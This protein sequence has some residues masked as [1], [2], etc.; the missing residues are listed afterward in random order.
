[1]QIGG[2]RVVSPDD[3]QFR[4]THRLGT[5]PGDRAVCARPRLGAHA[6]AHRP[7]KQVGGAQLVEEPQ[8]HAV[9]RQHAMGAGV[10]QGHHALRTPAVD[11][12]AHALV[13]DI[14]RLVPGDLAELSFPARPGSHE[15]LPDAPGPVDEITRVVSD[16]FA[17]HASRVT[18]RAGPPY[19]H[20]TVVLDGDGQAA[21]VGAVERANAGV[22]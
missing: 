10:V 15:R 11:H 22:L 18:K 9:A 13:D 12:G 2:R 7:A 8:R 1:M 4:L 6:A 21:G 3:G 17:Y 14:Q 19:L 20:D 16:L 5:D